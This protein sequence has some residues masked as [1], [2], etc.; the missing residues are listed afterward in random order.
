MT[1]PTFFKIEDLL[2]HC[3]SPQPKS[4]NPK[5]T[6]NRA[7]LCRQAVRSPAVRTDLSKFGILGRLVE[8]DPQVIR[9]QGHDCLSLYSEGSVFYVCLLTF[10]GCH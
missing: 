1:S 3:R 4:N 8:D 10:L 7:Q 2:L 9:L 5:P 6:E